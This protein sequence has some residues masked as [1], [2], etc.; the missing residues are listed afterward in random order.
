MNYKTIPLLIVVSIWYL[1]LP[2]PSSPVGQY[3]L[4]RHYGRGGNP[5]QPKTLFIDAVRLGRAPRRTGWVDQRGSTARR[6]MTAASRWSR[7]SECASHFGRLEVLK[8]VSL[9]VRQGGGLRPD[10]ALRLGQVDPPAHVDHLEKIDAGRIWVDGELV[11]YR[12]DGDKIHE[13]RETEIA[14]YRS[15]IGM[16]FQRFNLFPHMTALGNI[17]V[18]QRTVLKRGSNEAETEGR[19]LLERVGLG[20]KIDEYPARLSGGQQQRVAIARALAMD[21][22]LML[23]ERSR[24]RSIRNSSRRCST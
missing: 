6:A 19:E 10:R 23:F 1:A 4:E 3:F 12:Q 11:G 24:A 7:P 20:D 5:D 14:Q 18:A 16:V 15:K 22:K 8:R 9:E 2:P 13:L 17:V 21:P